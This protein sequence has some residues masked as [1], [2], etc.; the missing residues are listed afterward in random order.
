MKKEDLC[1]QMSHFQLETDLSTC[2]LKCPNIYLINSSAMLLC[3][4]IVCVNVHQCQN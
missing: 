1:A 3:F 2:L 4:C